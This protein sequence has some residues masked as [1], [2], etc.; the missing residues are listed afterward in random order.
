M[1][2]KDSRK[3]EVQNFTSPGHI[4]KVD[5]AKYEAMR[6]ALLTVLPRHQ[7][8]LTIAEANEKL[9]P[10]LSDELFPNG[11]KSG[12]WFKCVQLDLEAK[13]VIAREKTKPLRLHKT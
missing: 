10:L 4:Y 3:V 2:G 8:G 6:K 1:T 5:A 12:W 9:L 7:P 11:A 13:R